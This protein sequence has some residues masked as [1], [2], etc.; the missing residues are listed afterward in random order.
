MQ[1]ILSVSADAKTIKGEKFGVLTGIVYLAPAH[2]SGFN[3]CSDSTLE[4]EDVCLFKAGRGSTPPVYKARVKKTIS[5]F[6]ERTQFLE[7]TCEEIIALDKK[8]KK[9]NKIIAIRLNGTSDLP[10]EKIKLNNKSLME[11]FPNVQFYDY[12]KSEKR[13]FDFLLGRMPTN[14]HLTFSRSENNQPSC[15][16][17]LAL[18]GNVAAV[19]KNTPPK[20]YLG[21]KVVSGDES[22]LRFLDAKNV[23][24]ALTPKGK[25]KKSKGNFVIQ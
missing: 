10:W 24:V 13:M 8:A 2:E 14:Y 9:Q 16:R 12:T 1:T 15:S 19:F 7:K 20:K 17:V 23:I 25:A 6:K 4:C 3:T 18:G 22:D 5:L 21:K 11:L